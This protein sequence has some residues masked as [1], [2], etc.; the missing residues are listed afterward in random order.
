MVELLLTL[1]VLIGLYLFVSV[2]IGM[3]EVAMRNGIKHHWLKHVTAFVYAFTP[4][5]QIYIIYLS[6]KNRKEIQLWVLIQNCTE[7]Q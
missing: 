2:E 4:I 3:N 6:R 7:K 5:L 1:Y